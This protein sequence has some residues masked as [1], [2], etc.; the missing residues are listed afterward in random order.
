MR[1]QASIVSP[2][3]RMGSQ[4][5]IIRHVPTSAYRFKITHKPFL[6]QPQHILNL[7]Q[8]EDSWIQ[9]VPAPA[10]LDFSQFG[11]RSG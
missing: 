1:E 11:N 10:K 4:F 7:V 2:G 9:A 5:T 8:Y 6:I 3:S